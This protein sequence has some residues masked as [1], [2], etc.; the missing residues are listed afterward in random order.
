MHSFANT[1]W[2]K[3]SYRALRDVVLFVGA[4]LLANY[5]RFSVLWRIDDYVPAIVAGATALVAGNY[6][7]GLYSIES[8]RRSSFR[9]HLIL[10]LFAFAI[11]LVCITLT[12]YLS[13]DSRIGRGFM[14]LGCLFAL[15]LLIINH[16]IIYHKHR[17]APARVA[18]VA[19]SDEDIQEYLRIRELCPPGI[20]LVGRIGITKDG[21]THHDFLGRLPSTRKLIRQHKL[22]RIVFLDGLLNNEKAR[23]EFRMLRYLGFHCNS[24]ISECEKH[25]HYVPLHL[26]SMNWLL[27][28][29]LSARNLYFSKLKRLFDIVTSLLLLVVLAPFL[30]VGVAIV[31]IFSP[32]GPVL[33]KQER[34]GRFGRRFQIYKLRSMRTDAEKAGPVWSS[35]SKDP[36]VFPGGAFLRKYRIDEIPQLWN[37][38][39]GEM[40]F[41]G[42][43][44]E[45]P[46]FVASLSRAVPYYQERHMVQPG[47]TGWAQVCYPYG[48]STND[49]KCKLEYDLYYLKHA[50]VV[51]DCLI[52][53]DTIRVVL[54]GGLKNVAKGRYTAHMIEP[55]QQAVKESASKLQIEPLLSQP[56]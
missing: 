17:L 54:G 27:T 55:D 2:F 49:A 6:I 42:P 56:A 7:M 53:L 28:S 24:L 38:L 30:I 33:F 31:R 43:R 46:E 25:L 21:P 4:Y 18:F 15:P 52:L 8:H 22:D 47:L 40:S 36:R 14:A 9:L 39:R 11:A 20:Q 12:G 45:R 16:W 50:G 29:E 35:V 34:V 26:V 44:P 19:E 13:F 23:Q 10:L 32:E 51:F 5:A 48:S 37:V 41:V 1:H 3:A